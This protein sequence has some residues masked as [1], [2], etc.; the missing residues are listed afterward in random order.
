MQ[1]LNRQCKWG[2]ED[3]VVDLLD[4]KEW[5]E[6]MWVVQSSKVARA[7]VNM[8]DKSQKTLLMWAVSKENK[9]M[10]QVL[11]NCSDVELVDSKGKSSWQLQQNKRG[12]S[13]Q[14]G[15]VELAAV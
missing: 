6:L 11:K 8:A 13:G 15:L 12:S 2:E 5:T 1:V 4:S 14:Q 9:V 3:A 10:V 7:N